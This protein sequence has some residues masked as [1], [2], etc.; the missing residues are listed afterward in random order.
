MQLENATA[1]N[2]SR[3]KNMQKC[4]NT[5]QRLQLK[6]RHMKTHVYVWLVL[7]MGRKKN[8][9]SVTRQRLVAE[10]IEW[11][12]IGGLRSNLVWEQIF[13]SFL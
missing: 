11:C 9:S 5:K 13:V 1:T 12:R 7:Y 3:I 4:R 2:V 6:G 10:W 8:K